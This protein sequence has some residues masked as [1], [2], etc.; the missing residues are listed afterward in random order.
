MDKFVNRRG[1]IFLL[2]FTG[3]LPLGV[4]GPCHTGWMATNER[5]PS[6]KFH[7]QPATELSELDPHKIGIV[8]LKHNCKDPTKRARFLSQGSFKRCFSGLTCRTSGFSLRTL[9]TNISYH[10]IINIM[11]FLASIVFALTCGFAASQGWRVSKAQIPK[12]LS[13]FSAAIDADGMMY[14]AGGCGKYFC[15]WSPWTWFLSLSDQRLV[16]IDSPDGNVYV[17]TGNGT[18]TFECLSISDS[19]YQ[20]DPIKEV[21]TQLPNLPM[22]RYR[23]SGTIANNQLWIVGGR[24]LSDELIPQ[25]DVSINGLRIYYLGVSCLTF[26]LKF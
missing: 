16:F 20:F 2:I 15:W 4:L 7:R 13:D 23:H 12:S 19:L 1:N 17:N 22:K 5:Y 25:V 18:G 14:I 9:N 21:F 3:V 26:N 11:N 10:W 24:T 8:P 6:C